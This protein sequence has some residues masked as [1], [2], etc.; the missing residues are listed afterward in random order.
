[1]LKPGRL[2]LLCIAGL[3]AFGWWRADEVRLHYDKLMASYFPKPERQ[4]S[5]RR[6]PEGT[7]VTAVKAETRTMPVQREGIGS[8]VASMVVVVKAQVDGRLMAVEFK[9]G[10]IVHKG[11]VLARLD[12]AAFEAQ[13]E[14]AMA[15]VAQN[16]AGLRH[17]QLELERFERLA[18]ANAGTRQQADQQRA[19]V[20][21]LR[22]QIRADRAAADAARINLDHTVIVAPADG[23]AGIRLVDPGNIVRASDATGIVTLAQ[24]QPVSVIF[25]LPQRDLGVVQAAITR[26]VVNAAA[27]STDGRTTLASGRVEVIDNQIDQTTGTIRLKATFP[28]EDMKLWPGQFT[29]I[30]VKV[31]ELKDAVVIPTLA[32]RRG[33][34]GSFAYSIDETNKARVTPIEVLQ[35]DEAHAVIASGIVAGQSVVTAGFHLLRDGA[36][37]FVSD[38]PDVGQPNASPTANSNDRAVR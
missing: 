33:V 30:R 15:R 21:Q 20:A 23:R 16:E 14:Q 29:N 10:E 26:G 27:L 35:Q 4:A 6:R 11:Q 18:N 5:T 9:D 19:V 12:R 22:A 38:E 25:A 3:A 28:N 17:A 32:V 1:M 13:L 34:S 37:V 31:D 2:F 8:V 36:I 24:F 7:V